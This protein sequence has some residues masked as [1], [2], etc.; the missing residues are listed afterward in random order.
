M[1]ALRQQTGHIRP[2]IIRPFGFL[3]LL[4]GLRWRTSEGR[5]LLATAIIP[6]HSL[7]HELVPLA[8][9]LANRTEMTIY[10]VGTWLTV[11]WATSVQVNELGLPIT[12]ERTW[13]ALLLMGYLPMLFLVLRTHPI[14]N[15]ESGA[16]KKGERFVPFRISRN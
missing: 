4:A 5:L 2:P 11:L 16:Q 13:P 15:T 3:L 7:P 1:A 12:V 14:P 6:A 10:A 8:L 9:I